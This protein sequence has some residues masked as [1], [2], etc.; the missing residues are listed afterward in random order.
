M[1]GRHLAP[2]ALVVVVERLPPA[3]PVLVT[4]PVRQHLPERVGTRMTACHG[5][6]PVRSFAHAATSA[7]SSQAGENL[8]CSGIH[9]VRSMNRVEEMRCERVK[10]SR[11]SPA[12]RASIL[13]K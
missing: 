11:R 1:V 10:G 7:S 8:E 3:E 2:Q 6:R 12:S 4:G 9:P 5:L 13:D